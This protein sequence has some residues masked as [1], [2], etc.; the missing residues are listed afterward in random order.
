MQ[1]KVNLVGNLS[2]L[3]EMDDLVH[4]DF[5]KNKPFICGNLPCLGSSNLVKAVE[6]DLV[7]FDPNGTK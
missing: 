5:H 6:M 7:K 1:L 3:S 2:H 4:Y